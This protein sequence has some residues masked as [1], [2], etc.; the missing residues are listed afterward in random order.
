MN[1]YP[2]SELDAWPSLLDSSSLPQW[3]E[4][5]RAIRVFPRKECVHQQTRGQQAD[6]LNGCL[7]VFSLLCFHFQWRY[8]QPF[9]IERTVL[10]GNQNDTLN[11]MY[12]D[13]KTQLLD[14][15]IFFA[16]GKEV[17]GK[18]ASTSRHREPV[19]AR[20]FQG[21]VQEVVEMFPVSPVAAIDGGGTNAVLIESNGTL[22]Y[23]VAFSVVHVYKLNR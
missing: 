15:A 1:F 11:T 17:T 20:E 23:R 14:H 19:V 18:A 9:R 3:L 8:V 7:H 22:E 16:E 10:M 2:N 13:Q 5:N 4:T 21:V 12:R 6:S